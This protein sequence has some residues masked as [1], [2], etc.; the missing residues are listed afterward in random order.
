MFVRAPAQ[1][2]GI[3]VFR[4]KSVV[5]KFKAGI[6]FSIYPTVLDSIIDETLSIYIT[7]GCLDE[8]S[9]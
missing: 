2:R 8:Q 9:K 5:E 7:T 6:D 1:T 4:G 3:G